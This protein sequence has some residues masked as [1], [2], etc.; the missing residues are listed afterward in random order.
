MSGRAE[1]GWEFWIDRGG[2][3]TDC[4]GLAPDGGLRVAKVLSSDTA[5]LEGIWKILGVGPEDPLPAC[6]VKL[7]TTVATNALLERRGV[8]TLLVTSHG[9]GDVLRI[10]TQERP[11]L[12]DL[13]I[14]RPPPLEEEVLEL[15]ARVGAHGERVGELDP[16]ALRRGLEAARGQGIH[17]VAVVLPHSYAHPEDEARAVEIAREM[18]FPYAVASS[19]VAR[20]LGFLARG[21]T[22]VADAYLTPLLQA[23]V[24][25]LSRA[26]PGSRLAFMQSSGGLTDAARF[27]G[28]SAL[29]SGPAGGVVGAAR[30]AREAGFASAIGFDMGGTSTDV[31]LVVE[32]EVER[33][34][35]SVVAGVRVK[36]PMMRIHTVAAG[37]G[38]LCRFDGFRLTVGPE[39]AGADPGPLCYDLC[40]EAGLPRARELALTDVNLALGRLQPDRFPF[41]ISIEP[42]RAALARLEGELRAAGQP[43]SVDAIAAGFVEVA[44]AA[45]VQAIAQVSV[46][47]GVDPRDHAL[48]GFGGAAGQ[49]VCAIARALGIRTILLHPLAGLLSAYGIGS[50]ETSFDVQRDAGRLALGERLPDTVA[51]TLVAL[52]AEGRAALEAEGVSAAAIAAERRLDLR[53]VG[54]ETPLPIPEPADGD[55]R[56]A[57]AR[58]HRRRFGY[59]RPG[60]TIEIVTA[61]VRTSAPGPGAHATPEPAP[62]RT[63]PTPLR[64]ASVWFPDAGRLEAPV[65]ARAELGPGARVVGPALLLEDTGTI[66]VDAGF[67]GVLDARGILILRDRGTAVVRKPEHDLTR[68]DPIRLEVFGNRFMSIA[69]QMGAV[70]R[71]TA[72]STNIKER[73]DFSCAVFDAQGGLVANAPHI[74]VH[75]GAMAETVRT[76]RGRFP[77]LGPG[78]AVVSNDP[79]EG[80]SHLPDVTVVSPVFVDGEG[81]PDFFVASRGHHADI[82]GRTPGSMPPDSRRLEE[83]GVVLHAFRLV[84]DGRFDEAG[85]RDRLASGPYP[86][87]RPD[88]NVADLEAMLASNRTGIDL[89]RAMVA[90]EG[91]AAV[92]TTMQQ[93]QEAAAAKVAREIGRLADGEHG[94][95]DALDDGTPV[96]VRLSVAGERMVIDFAGTGAAL[97]GNLNAPR[98]VVQAAVIYVLRCLVRER[99]PLNGGCLAPVEIRIPSGSLLDPPP[100]HAVVGGNVETS[101]RIVDVLLGALGRAGASQGTMNNVAFGDRTFGYYETIGGGAGAGP[102]FE[103]ASGVHTH[104]TNTRITDLEVLEARHPVRIERFALRRGSGGAGAQRGGDG[105]VRVYRFLAP[106]TVSL[107][108]ERR[109]IAPYGMADGSPGAPGE[110]RIERAEGRVEALGSKA[111]A[112]LA[113]GDRLVV[114]TPGGGGF[115]RPTL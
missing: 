43:L 65:Y 36:A 18:G 33:A 69:E 74:P 62:A 86:A 89:L 30:V 109:L 85:L 15:A 78:D 101:Q 39:S 60:R 84:A 81:H 3:F 98:A 67:E 103:G 97:E 94:F 88:D 26:L 1:V 90:Q 99:I 83:E 6:R 76:V 11:E 16:D 82:G 93:L 113:A 52:E 58:A 28:P 42:V 17:A 114:E 37:G 57:F 21:E 95:R 9:L 25:E 77:D 19:E 51:T 108:S 31:S 20:E 100:G 22:A 55:W 80:G 34:F 102:D 105:L 24:H 53:Y 12:F 35:E 104:M 45:M 56:A 47:R 106:V 10:G 59:E 41:P 48:V 110:N 32:G 13:A 8:R 66:V 72:F 44:N 115:G 29:L 5:A 50:A 73:L 14:E 111:T 23:H 87:R 107:L 70:L 46:A 4:I 91:V 79:F 27:R 49:H 2:T 96:V 61:R 63:T 64:H 71:N 75:L 54:T 68:A 92:R 38:S 7:G 112:E 40:D